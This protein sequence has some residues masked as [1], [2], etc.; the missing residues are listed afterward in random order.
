VAPPIGAR[1]TPLAHAFDVSSIHGFPGRVPPGTRPAAFR[2]AVPLHPA[3]P[4]RAVSRTPAAAPPAHGADWRARF[5]ALTRWC[6]SDLPLAES[7]AGAVPLSRPTLGDLLR[8]ALAHDGAGVVDLLDALDAPESAATRTLL[9]RVL[10]ADLLLVVVTARGGAMVRSDARG[11]RSEAEARALVSA[12]LGV[13]APDT[14]ARAGV[15]ARDGAIGPALAAGVDGELHDA[16]TAA[17]A[18]HDGD[19][20]E[21]T[22]VLP[23]LFLGERPAH[24][25]VAPA[26]VAQKPPAPPAM[27]AMPAMPAIL[28]GTL[29]P[30]AAF[31]DAAEFVGV[32]SDEDA[33]EQDVDDESTA[34]HADDDAAGDDDLADD[35]EDGFAEGDDH[36]DASTDA[37]EPDEPRPAPG[38]D[39]A[40]SAP[41]F[42]AAPPRAAP[43]PREEATDDRVPDAEVAGTLDRL[44]AR[45]RAAA[46]RVSVLIASD[47]GA[48]EH[49]GDAAAWLAEASEQE[50]RALVRGG[51]SGDAA[52]EV[53]LALADDDPEALDVVRV[54]RRNEAELVVE[55]DA[56]AAGAWLAAHRP[57][58][59][60]RLEPQPR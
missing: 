31:L 9:G 51:W 41:A 33:D 34:E 21:L 1:R 44:R 3:A 30:G 48:A 57:D 52:A 38:D 59:A 56:D 18:P 4:A 19:A 26:A 17:D 14:A 5:D 28:G 35:R 49:V 16:S 8:R 10:G 47:D 37:E 13:P 60:E 15:V 53:A 11:C 2:A 32:A 12:F 22:I 29:R 55:I 50:L 7:V 40:P 39:L 24:A 58:V 46:E 43:A 20:G 6:L 42:T 25:S 23:F 54:A 45:T 36:P 27:P